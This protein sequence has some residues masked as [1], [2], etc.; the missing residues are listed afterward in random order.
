ML[1]GAFGQCTSERLLKIY[2]I[3]SGTAVTPTRPAY[4]KEDSLIS[5]ELHIDAMPRI[6]TAS[7]NKVKK[8]PEILPIGNEVKFFHGKLRACEAEGSKHWI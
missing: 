7:L 8:R 2:T 3:A 6:V 1:N 5:Y 4:E